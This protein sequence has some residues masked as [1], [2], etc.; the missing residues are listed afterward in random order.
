[1][2]QG[3]CAV[4]CST[5]SRL[6]A[7]I[8]ATLATFGVTLFTGAATSQASVRSLSASSP[9][10]TYTNLRAS[11]IPGRVGQ[12]VTY[13]ATVTPAPDGGTVAFSE[14]GS[15]IGGCG[16]QTVA[17]GTA[18]CQV[19]YGG[20]GVHTVM[21]TYSGDSNYQGSSGSFGEPVDR[22]LTSNTLTASPNPATVG[23]V[24]TYTAQ[25]SPAPNG[26]T[27]TFLYVIN[28]ATSWITGC[29]SP[30]VSADGT[31]T[32]QVVYSG[33]GTYTLEASYFDGVGAYESA[34]SSLFTETVQGPSSANS[35]PVV[36]APVS[37]GGSQ[38]CTVTETL[39]TTVTTRNGVVVSASAA[40]LVHRIVVVG[41]R[42]VTVAGG[43]TKTVSVT[44]N[45][46]GRGIIRRL[47]TLPIVLTVK[48]KQR[49]KRAVTTRRRLTILA[50]RRRHKKL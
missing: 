42:S 18:T 7:V 41:T 26:G 19:T 45:A 35:P 40:R 3:V 1:M 33:P 32:C 50:P 6:V 21:A 43:R 37:C 25:V 28:D 39:T 16:A 8:V 13:T 20:V 17:S 11:P 27:E 12:V 15:P 38:A 36:S 10:S 44:L 49:G 5:A 9:V 30:T 22:V 14:A 31:A 47:G 2:F 46:V 4:R 34:N 29:G 23:E 24:V 48:N